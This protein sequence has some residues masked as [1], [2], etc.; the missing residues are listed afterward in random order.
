MWYNPE[1]ECE[2]TR[3]S[4]EKSP[5]EYMIH[6]IRSNF[7]HFQGLQND[8]LLQKVVGWPYSKFENIGHYVILDREME[9]LIYLI[10]ACL[11]MS[12]Y[13]LKYDFSDILK[14]LYK[15]FE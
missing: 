7:D 15:L 11:N 5:T 3:I 14:L 8:F 6:C 13:L 2:H 4:R 1:A 9:T 12:S 10:K